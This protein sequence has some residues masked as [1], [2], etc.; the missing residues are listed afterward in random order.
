[1]S[2]IYTK[3]GDQGITS[4]LGGKRVRKDNL[5]VDTY[6]SIDEASSALGLAYS[7]CQVT[8]LKAITREI[9]QKLIKVAAEIAQ[10]DGEISSL[11]VRT[12]EEDVKK[13]EK[14][15]DEIEEIKPQ[16]EGFIFSGET[17]SA[18]AFDLARSIVRRAERRIL[19]LGEEISLNSHL[20]K[21]LNRLSD[22]L[23]VMAR[24]DEFENIVKKVTLEVMRT[25]TTFYDNLLLKKAKELA[26]AAEDHAEKINVPMVISAVDVNGNLVLFHRMDNSLLASIDISVNKAYTAAAVRMPTHKLGEL[27]QPGNPLYGIETTNKGRMV[28]FGGGYPLYEKEKFIGGLGISGGTVEEDM[29]VAETAIKSLS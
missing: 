5:Q 22:L 28:I 12:T 29:E 26:Q 16:Q 17:S 20:P 23:F 21:Y 6:G 27:S 10:G 11:V 9:Q 7:F 15:I 24:L 13:L 1:M 3:T 18:A 25:M 8:K 4:L 19:S 2:R 14:Y